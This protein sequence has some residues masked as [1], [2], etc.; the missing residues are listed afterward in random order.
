MKFF[1]VWGVQVV[2]TPLGF[3]LYEVF[4]KKQA[5]AKVLSSDA[6]VAVCLVSDVLSAMVLVCIA[7]ACSPLFPNVP[8][9][10]PFK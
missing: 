5:L 1:F 4:E 10:D 7:G 9:R 8:M 6:L 2:M 3:V